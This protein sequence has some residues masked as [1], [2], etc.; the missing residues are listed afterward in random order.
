MMHLQ[1]KKILT[2]K[3][4]MVLLLYKTLSGEVKL[5]TILSDSRMVRAR[6]QAKFE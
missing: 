3:S 5:K 2:T 6:L 4:K 1:L